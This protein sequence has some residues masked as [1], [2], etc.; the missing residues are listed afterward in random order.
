MT[1]TGSVSDGISLGVQLLVDNLRTFLLCVSVC[2][3]VGDIYVTRGHA[4]LTRVVIDTNGEVS[5]QVGK[6]FSF[7]PPSPSR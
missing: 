6:L 1:G 5:G 3:V 7:I 2:P 4:E